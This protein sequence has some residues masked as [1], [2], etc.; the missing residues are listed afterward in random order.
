M[1][2]HQGLVDTPEIKEN[3]VC[4]HFLYLGGRFPFRVLTLNQ[5]F[6]PLLNIA[7]VRGDLEIR[8]GNPDASG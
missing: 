2:A 4:T 1:E 6:R 7:E 8:S 3:A 5:T